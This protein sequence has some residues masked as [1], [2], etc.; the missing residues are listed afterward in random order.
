[1]AETKRDSL[2]EKVIGAAIE[3]HRALVL[4]SGNTLAFDRRCIPRGGVARAWRTAGQYA[5]VLA[6]CPAGPP[7][8][9]MRHRISETEHLGPGLL[10]SAYE[11]CL[12]CELSACNAPFR[13]Q[14]PLPVRYKNVQS[15]YG[16][17]ID[18]VIEGALSV[19]IK[20]AEGLTRFYEAQLLTYLRL[21]GLRRGLLTNFNVLLLKAG[22]KRF[23]L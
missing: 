3:V 15:V 11:E 21:S 9:P 1:M 7:A 20:A 23:V 2:S 14:A 19:E 17:R 8:P 4:R 10:E 5:G 12:C 16:Y 6:P 22:I 13:R 18:L